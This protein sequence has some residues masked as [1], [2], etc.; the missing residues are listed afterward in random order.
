MVKRYLVDTTSLTAYVTGRVPAQE[1]ISPWIERQEVATSILVY[2]E[3][4]EYIQ[5]VPNPRPRQ[6][7]LRRILQE[8]SP[9]VPTI[10][11]LERYATLRRRLRAPHGPGLTGDIDT[12]IAA[13][14]LEHGLVL[15]TTDTDF[16]RVPD[17]DLM[18]LP[19]RQ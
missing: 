8:V 7:Q 17:L 18:L 4:T 12:L 1:L 11:I 14:A 9:Y 16:R 13:T 6:A 10:A 19:R 5:G 15:V 3:I 2:G